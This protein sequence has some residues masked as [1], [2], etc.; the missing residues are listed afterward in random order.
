MTRETREEERIA[1]LRAQIA[2]DLTLLR[3]RWAA[4]APWAR[5]GPEKWTAQAA[6]LR[7]VPAWAAGALAGLLAAAWSVLRRPRKVE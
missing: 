4:Q 3:Q 5:Y 6:R 2:A 7:R 1:Q